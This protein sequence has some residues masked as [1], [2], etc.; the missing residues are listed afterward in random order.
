MIASL[1]AFGEEPMPP[2]RNRE[3]EVLA[4]ICA[5]ALLGLAYLCWRAVGWFGVGLLGLLVLFIAV[6]IDLEGNR[7]IGSPTTPELYASQYRG[8]AMQGRSEQ[9]GRAA[10][11]GSVM[12]AARLAGLFGGSLAITGF[13]LFFLL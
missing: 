5:I 11:R 8:E 1:P 9:A 6:R 7:S 2:P 12:T 13:G 4:I 3:R 10:E